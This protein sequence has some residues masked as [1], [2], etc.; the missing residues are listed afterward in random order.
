VLC[1]KKETALMPETADVLTADKGLGQFT[2][3]ISCF[4]IMAFAV[5]HDADPTKLRPYISSS[6]VYR[7][8]MITIDIHFN[9][10][11]CAYFRVAFISANTA[12]PSLNRGPQQPHALARSGISPHLRIPT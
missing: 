9:I 5:L 11:I 3:L 1:S 10:L 6:P 8:A 4:A 2:G 7:T 12:C